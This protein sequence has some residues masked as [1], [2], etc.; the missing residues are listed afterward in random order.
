MSH[1]QENGENGRKPV[2]SKGTKLQQTKPM[3][4]KQC[5]TW[6]CLA[7]LLVTV[8]LSVYEA[9]HVITPNMPEP[10]VFEGCSLKYLVVPAT[11]IIVGTVFVSRFKL[12]GSQRSIATLLMYLVY[13]VS[14]FVLC[15]TFSYFVGAQYIIL[16]PSLSLFDLGWVCTLWIIVLPV[17]FLCSV[18]TEVIA[19]NKRFCELMKDLE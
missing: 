9:M 16:F 18:V 12:S 13:A 19:K 8:V 1:V 10:P 3:P 6:S 7:A 14:G 11:F 2:E 5:V 4:Y 15:Q 17:T